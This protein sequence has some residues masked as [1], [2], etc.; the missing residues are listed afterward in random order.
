LRRF[1]WAFWWLGV[2]R[3]RPGPSLSSDDP[4]RY[5]R[6]RPTRSSPAA[7]HL[8]HLCA[9]IRPRRSEHRLVAQ[10]FEPGPEAARPLAVERRAFA[11]APRLQR[12]RVA[13]GAHEHVGSE[14]K[15]GDKLYEL[16]KGPFE[17][18]LAARQAALAQLQATLEN[19]RLTTERARAC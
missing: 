18:D 13:F 2:A 7:L 10:R 8:L 3:R 17:A 1:C 19:A 15:S 6:I 4:G 11:V 12:R 14:V 5:T 16:E 9:A